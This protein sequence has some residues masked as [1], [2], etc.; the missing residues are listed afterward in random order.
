MIR[1]GP[2]RASLVALLLG[3]WAPSPA[4][5][6]EAPRV[7]VL[8]GEHGGFTRL[9]MVLPAAPDWRLGRRGAGYGLRLAAPAGVAFDLSGVWDRI[10]RSRIATLTAT[11]G[12]LDLDLGCA[13]HAEAFIDGTR[14]LVIDIRPGPPPAGSPFEAP[15]ATAEAA[16][17]DPPSARP[18]G[19]APAEA[20]QAAPVVPVVPGLQARTLADGRLIS[21]ATSGLLRAPDGTAPPGLRLP[22]E[23]FADVLG[24]VAGLA[25]G[26]APAAVPDGGPDPATPPAPATPPDPDPAPAPDPGTSGALDPRILEAQEDLIRG[27]GE[28]AARGAVEIDRALPDFAATPADEPVGPPT[29]VPPLH[30]GDAVGGQLLI[31]DDAAIPRP[32]STADGRACLA[33]AVLDIAAWGRAGT[34]GEDIAAGRRKLVGE[35]DRPDPEAVLG[36]VRL[37]LHAGF[38]AE[39]KTLLRAFAPPGDG[40]DTAAPD[41]PQ[42]ALRALGPAY[43]V[44]ADIL[45]DR[46]VPPGGAFAGMAPCDGH[47]ALWAVLAEGRLVPGAPV[48]IPAVLRGFS[49]LPVHLR[50]TMGP[51][52]VTILLEGGAQDAV[53]TLQRMLA[54]APGGGGE[55]LGLMV[56]R[57]DLAAGRTEAAEAGLGAIVTANSPFSV[58]ALA[59]LVDSVVARGSRIDPDMMLTLEALAREEGGGPDAPALIRALALAR[60]AAGDAEGAFAAAAR[61]PDGEAVATRVWAVLARAPDPGALMGRALGAAQGGTTPALPDEVRVAVA[62]RL[63]DLGFAAEAEVWIGGG[64]APEARL[65][66]AEARLRRGDP[67][68]ALAAL[69]GL[70]SEAAAGLRGRALRLAGAPAEAAAAFLEAGATAEAQR[71]QLQARAWEAA[72]TGPDAALGAPI[73]AL[74]GSPPAALPEARVPNTPVEGMLAAGRD[75]LAGAARQ[76]E[77]AAALVA[78]IAAPDP[79]SPV[80]PSPDPPPADRPPA[81][82]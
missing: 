69:E 64:A 10:D 74:L 16:G 15:L 14:V 68:G 70:G 46:P 63:L 51:P 49:A 25:G 21:H 52:L 35:F 2:A 50:A 42:G 54:R 9:A 82:P 48:A 40:P 34:L 47:A 29:P 55:A 61:T 27:L 56:A 38:G 65:M 79:P 7:P 36:L 43:E 41:T 20:P 76:R 19:G 11:P 5:G 30:L 31:R 12:G 1:G 73:A 13:C 45:D 59:D 75:I 60:A 80:L 8:S 28:A 66:L 39:A 53:V 23:R 44:I 17:G 72:A 6:Q 58:A 33:D 78:R 3:L 57:I 37:Y 67:A 24:P 62:R 22:H 26:A 77:A 32:G 71:A 81:D 18:E 4:P